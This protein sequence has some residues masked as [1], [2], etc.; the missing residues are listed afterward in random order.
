MIL[1][2]SVLCVTGFVF[3]QM[4]VGEA[5]VW[6]MDEPPQSLVAIVP[7]ASV[8]GNG[9]PSDILKD[10]LLTALELYESGTV[11]KILVSGDGGSEDYNEVV[12]MRDFL[13]EAGAAPEDVFLDHAGFDSYDTMHRARDVFGADEAI[14]VSQEYHLPR[15]LYIGRELGI[16]AYGVTS[17]RQRYIKASFF[18]AREGLANIKAVFEVTVGSSPKFLGELI[19]LSGDGTVTH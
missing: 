16:E 1:L 9:T 3:V 5:A 13:L 18:K 17:D 6:I 8:L 15:L 14:V 4:R 11:E 12:V 10:R 19:D 2:T 7:G